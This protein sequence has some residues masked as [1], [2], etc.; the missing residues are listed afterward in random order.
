MHVNLLG[1]SCLSLTWITLIIAYK[2][3]KNIAEKY[4]AKNVTLKDELY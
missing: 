1:S 3:H 4:S 2:A